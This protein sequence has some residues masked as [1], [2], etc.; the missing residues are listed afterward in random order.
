[1]EIRINVPGIPADAEVLRSPGLTELNR[2]LE[3]ALNDFAK[4][5]KDESSA[6]FAGAI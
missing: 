2:T 4:K 5:H 6:A 1:M 3:N